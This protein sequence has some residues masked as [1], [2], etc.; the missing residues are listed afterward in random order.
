MQDQQAF[1]RIQSDTLSS[2]DET[3]A[4]FNCHAKENNSVMRI[5][6]FTR[7]LELQS[8]EEWRNRIWQE[9][10]NLTLWIRVLF[11]KLIVTQLL[12]YPTPWRFIT[13]FTRARHRLLSWARWIQ[14]TP[15]RP[16]AFTSILIFSSHLDLASRLFP[17][18]VPT[19]VLRF[20]S[21]LCV[22]HALPI[23]LPVTCL[24]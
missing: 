8:I 11:D 9:E 6:P 17:S 10:N 7:S 18:S 3:V 19:E 14:F 22:L 23:L 24:S 20:L 12:K 4:L 1:P 16:V 15:S 5:G 21:F 2:C 13:E